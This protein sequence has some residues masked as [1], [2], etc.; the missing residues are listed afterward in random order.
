VNLAVQLAGKRVSAPASFG[1]RRI[2]DFEPYSH[3]CDRPDRLVHW[4]GRSPDRSS[5]AKRYSSPL[6]SDDIDI[7][8]RASSARA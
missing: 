3:V 7:S 6:G 2:K 4:V 1:E 8:R 5:F